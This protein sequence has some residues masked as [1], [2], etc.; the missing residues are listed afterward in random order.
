MSAMSELDTRFGSLTE[1][2]M[3]MVQRGWFR[4]RKRA[5]PLEQ[6]ASVRQDV[7]RYTGLGTLLLLLAAGMYATLPQPAGTWCTALISIGGA[8]LMWGSPAVVITTTGGYTRR[9]VGTPGSFAEA[10]RFVAGLR[11]ALFEKSLRR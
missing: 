1:N 2:T 9:L 7:R 5:I 3:V 4:T 8:V 10:D 11:Q 6:I